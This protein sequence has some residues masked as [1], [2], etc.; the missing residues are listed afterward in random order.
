MP[1]LKQNY[2]HVTTSV[3]LTG[4][5]LTQFTTQVQSHFIAVWATKLNVADSGDI[6]IIAGSPHAVSRRRQLL[7]AG[8]DVTFDV[9]VSSEGKAA[10]TSTTITAW[11]EDTTATGFRAQLNTA[12]PSSVTIA[13][14]EIS[15]A[16]HTQLTGTTAPTAAPPSLL[17]T[18]LATASLVLSII[19]VVSII[20]VTVVVI[21][22]VMLLAMQMKKTKDTQHHSQKNID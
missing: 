17:N 21:V 7:A 22:V 3:R 10:W 8:V 19:G 13:V 15:R 20:L 1:T 14:A 9:A 6:T 4:L 2:F 12:T 11:V 16:P 18:D 5:T